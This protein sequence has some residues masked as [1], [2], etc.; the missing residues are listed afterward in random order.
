MIA[1]HKEKAPA[2][3]LTTRALADP[4]A[5]PWFNVMCLSGGGST[6]AFR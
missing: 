3:F 5:Y 4:S 2:A 1:P 6:R